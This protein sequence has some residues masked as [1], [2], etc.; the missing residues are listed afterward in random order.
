MKVINMAEESVSD[1][2]I[3][4]PFIVKMFYDFKMI[5][6]FIFNFF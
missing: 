5:F 6:I 4:S 3:N 1:N 2:H